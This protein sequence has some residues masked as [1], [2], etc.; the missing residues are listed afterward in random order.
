MACMHTSGVV[1]PFS[2]QARSETHRKT[3]PSIAWIL[4]EWPR[5]TG[6]RQR[7]DRHDDAALNC[8][9]VLY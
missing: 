2:I 3:Y 5:S 6:A 9:H 7:D 4:Q 1:V 8:M